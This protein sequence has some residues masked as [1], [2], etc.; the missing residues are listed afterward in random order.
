MERGSAEGGGGGGARS[1]GASLLD[2]AR[3]LLDAR[4]L[5][6]SKTFAERAMEADPL[7]DGVDW[8]MATADVLLAAQRRRIN[9]HADLYAILQIDPSSGGCGTAAVRLQYSRLARLLHPRQRQGSHGFLSF[10]ISAAADEAFKLVSDAWAVLS[11]PVKK[12]LYDKEIDIAGTAH[13]RPNGASAGGH[14]GGPALG[15]GRPLKPTW[16]PVLL[17]GRHA[18][19]ASRCTSMHL[20]MRAGF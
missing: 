19:A 12:E 4:D 2:I 10:S 8:I 17:S 6:G 3:K 7:L 14:K 13:A 9:N 18:R 16:T 20:D 1:E 11:D 15:T 5:V